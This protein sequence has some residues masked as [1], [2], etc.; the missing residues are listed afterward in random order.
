MSEANVEAFRRGIEAYNRRDRATSSRCLRPRTP[1]ASGIRSR[2]RSRPAPAWRPVEGNEAYLGHAGIRQWWAN[3]DAAF[4][5]F[6]VSVEEVRDLGD[7]VLALGRLRSRS[8]SGVALDT[9][10]GWMIRYRDG[11][12]VW[13][14]NYRTHAETLA[15]ADRMSSR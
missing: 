3:L 10:V 6:E 12:A 9:E 13:G 14:R 5:E 4:E 15:A 7:V 1:S 11:L 2:P 8:R